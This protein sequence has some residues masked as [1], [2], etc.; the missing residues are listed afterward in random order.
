MP[1]PGRGGYGR[2]RLEGDG[3]GA[4]ASAGT[5]VPSWPSEGPGRAAESLRVVLLPGVLAV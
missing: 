2:L 5:P 4:G 3:A 1:Y